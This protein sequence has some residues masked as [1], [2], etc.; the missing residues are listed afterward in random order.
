MELSVTTQERDLWANDNF[1]IDPSDKLE[2][3]NG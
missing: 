2:V 1:F 3:P